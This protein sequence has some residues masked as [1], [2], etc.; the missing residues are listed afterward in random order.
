MSPVARDA[1]EVA[2]RHLREDAERE[3]ARWDKP[4]P[5]TTA[6]GFTLT[7]LTRWTGLWRLDAW[8]W[9]REA[10]QLED[11]AGETAGVTPEG[12]ALLRQR[13]ARLRRAARD[14]RPGEGGRA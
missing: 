7:P 5:E 2:A 1:A 11:L 9:N 6:T 12:A 4:G 3:S 10:R 14:A 13:A 8:L